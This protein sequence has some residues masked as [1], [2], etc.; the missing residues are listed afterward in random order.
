MDLQQIY[1][2]YDK[3][4]NIVLLKGKWNVKD[5]D[6]QLLFNQGKLLISRAKNSRFRSGYAAGFDELFSKGVV[7]VDSSRLQVI[8]PYSSHSS[9]ANIAGNTISLDDIDLL[10]EPELAYHSEKNKMT[11]RLIDKYVGGA[12]DCYSIKVAYIMRDTVKVPRSVNNNPA[13]I[14]VFNNDLEN[15][16]SVVIGNK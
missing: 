12:K 10:Y 3:T 1:V 9:K 6:Q 13:I 15:P 11:K 7:S 14:G 5:R 16:K 2:R 4:G 8:T